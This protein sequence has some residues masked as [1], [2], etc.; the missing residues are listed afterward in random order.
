MAV[1]YFAPSDA[2]LL[3]PFDAWIW[4]AALVVLLFASVALHELGHS[5]VA[6]SFGVPVRSITL[7]PIGGVSALSEM[8]KNPR[9]E[10]MIAAAGPLVSFGLA[11]GF[12]IP[13]WVL[14]G[15]FFASSAT[16]GVT[17]IAETASLNALL[18]VFN[19]FLPAFPMDGGRLLRAGLTPRM[20]LA[21]ATRRAAMVGRVLAVGMAVIGLFFGGFLL[22]L[23]AIFV[24]MGAGQEERGV[25]ITHALG[26]LTLGD[27]MT[28]PAEVVPA[29]LPVEDAIRRM[30]SARH[31]HLP[32][33]AEDG[34]VTAV[35]RVSDVA[36][37]PPAERWMRRV[38]EIAR[39]PFVARPASFLAA[40]SLPL[41][42]AEADMLLVID[43][44]R[45][46]LGVVTAT[47]LAR[48][49]EM[50]TVASGAGR[51]TPPVA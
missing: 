34:R 28:A 39:G 22:I 51:H 43:A 14:G 47:D 46:L 30:Q 48:T 10:A 12:G 11:L 45:R 7:L 27:L 9:R 31:R 37:V 17:L 8:P 33:V 40:E 26:R 3:P 19:M 50:A 36:A 42:S 23:V 13:A 1:S 32:V 2:S 5:V 15:H 41:L 4:G 35:L 16:P 21:E 6:R 20:G 29:N 24:W 44:A 18:G 38:G 49:V 25:L